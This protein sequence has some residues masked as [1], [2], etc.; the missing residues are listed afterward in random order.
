MQ[1]QQDLSHTKVRSLKLIAEQWGKKPTVQ[2]I[3]N[4]E[5]DV[6]TRNLSQGGPVMP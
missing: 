1:I 2:S 5:W 3:S 4:K 6:T